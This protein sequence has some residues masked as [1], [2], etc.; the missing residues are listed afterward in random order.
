MALWPPRAVHFHRPLKPGQVALLIAAAFTATLLVVILVA[1]RFFS[2]PLLDYACSRP[3]QRAL[4]GR[5][6]FVRAHLSD[7]SGFEVA[8]YD[9]EDGGSAH[10]AL[11]T[12]LEPEA[13][14]ET[15]LIDQNCVPYHPEADDEPGV[16]CGTGSR[17]SLLFF[18]TASD[19]TT[20]GELQLAS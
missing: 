19:G 6:D 17:A 13:A 15:L 20:T 7:A 16:L 2:N 10:L 1:F 5:E 18:D 12:S 3:G 11:K 8:S 9:C 14:R 4:T